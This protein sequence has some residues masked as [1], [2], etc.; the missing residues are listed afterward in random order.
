MLSA[1]YA[2]EHLIAAHFGLRAGPVLHWWFPVYDPEFSR[3]DPG[4]M[5]LRAVLEAGP[6]L[7]LERIDLGRGD[8]E[9]KRWLGTGYQLVCQ[10]AVIRNPLRHRT[11]SARRRFTQAAKVL[12]GGARP[13][14]R[15]PLRPPPR[16]LSAPSTAPALGPAFAT[17]P[18]ARGRITAAG[19]REGRR[20]RSAARAVASRAPRQAAGRGGQ[21]TRRLSPHASR[22]SSAQTRAVGP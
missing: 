8:G 15:R 1:V 7:G 16:P 21:P 20:H 12:T 9:W 18:H 17:L 6:E 3:L 2:G 14:E 5:Q 10:G 19:M 22:L 11:A 13:A 4:W